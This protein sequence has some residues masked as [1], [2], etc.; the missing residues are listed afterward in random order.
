MLTGRSASSRLRR[1]LTS[2][3]LLSRWCAVTSCTASSLPPSAAPAAARLAATTQ[4]IA[5]PS[6]ARLKL[7]RKLHARRGRER[8]G[9]VVV[10]GQRLLLD[11]LDALQPDAFEFVL[12]SDEWADADALEALG[13]PT[14]PPI[15]PIC[16]TPLFPYLTCLFL[17]FSLVT[18]L[19]PSQLLRAPA[20]MVAE[21]SDTQTPQGCLGVLR[22]PELEMPT[23]PDLVLVLDRLQ[24]KH[25]RP[26]SPICGGRSHSV[27]SHIPAFH[28]VKRSVTGDAAAHP[29]PPDPTRPHHTAHH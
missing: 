18:R 17:F 11:A 12:L 3:L 1:S 10:E 2:T 9:L 25:G 27:F 29:T 16:R 24:E 21:V 20:K 26:I 14:H 22:Q 28:S 15:S 7:L 6:N 23:E 13:E 8:T 5:S 4:L 19:E